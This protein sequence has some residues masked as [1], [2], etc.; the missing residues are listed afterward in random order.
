MSKGAKPSPRQTPDAL[1]PVVADVTSFSELCR[2]LYAR[3]VMDLPLVERIAI[4]EPL[5]IR[6]GIKVSGGTYRHQLTA[7]RNWER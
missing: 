4:A 3:G 2:R 5:A 6:L 1:W 7:S